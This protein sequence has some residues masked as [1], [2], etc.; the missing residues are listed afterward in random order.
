[1]LFRAGTGI[2]KIARVHQLGSCVSYG[3]HDN[4]TLSY[5]Y[6]SLL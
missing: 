6:A 3:E 5:F 1:M 2:N 4:F